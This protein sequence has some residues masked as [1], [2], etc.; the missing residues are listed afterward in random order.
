MSGQWH[1][2]LLRLWKNKIIIKKE[3]R[4][5]SRLKAMAVSQT[6]RCFYKW[7]Q[8]YFLRLWAFYCPPAPAQ[9]EWPFLLWLNV[10]LHLS[11]RRKHDGSEPRI[12]ATL[13]PQ[14]F[15]PALPYTTSPFHK[16]GGQREGRGRVCVCVWLSLHFD[17]WPYQID[18]CV[19]FVAVIFVS[20]C[21]Y[22]CFCLDAFIQSPVDCIHL[23]THCDSSSSSSFV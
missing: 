23:R 2:R 3:R 17:L 9:T 22:T 1:R 15:Q 7:E 6:M 8:E 10:L 11:D 4:S 18:P 19:T 13:E 21:L 14:L 16:V 12:S 5:V 20:S